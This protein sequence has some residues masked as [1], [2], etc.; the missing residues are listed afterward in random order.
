MKNLKERFILGLI[1]GILGLGFLFGFFLIYSF[2]AIMLFDNSFPCY[3]IGLLYSLITTVM[4]M[5]TL[6]D[7]DYIE[8]NDLPNDKKHKWDKTRLS[9]VIIGL[10]FLI[11]LFPCLFKYF[12]AVKSL[13]CFF[14]HL[15]TW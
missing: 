7:G 10:I 1:F 6:F 12:P 8:G 2:W 14:E 11:I 15:M 13:F 5:I 9:V 3:S 4:L